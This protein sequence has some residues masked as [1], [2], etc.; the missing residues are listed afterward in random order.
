MLFIGA[1]ERFRKNTLLGED[2]VRQPTATTITN[3][4]VE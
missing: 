2:P 1:V 4:V 3:N